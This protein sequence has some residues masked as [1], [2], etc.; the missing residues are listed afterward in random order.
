MAMIGG[1]TA[2]GRNPVRA[3]DE[4]AFC[5]STLG[6]EL[7]PVTRL[8]ARRPTLS[9]VDG[10]RVWQHGEK[11]A[12]MRDLFEQGHSSPGHQVRHPMTRADERIKL[13]NQR[14]A[15]PPSQ[16]GHRAQPPA[17]MVH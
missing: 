1:E 3:L 7:G 5:R 16:F 10:G 2:L 13:L 12:P 9:P 11:S 15:C 14:H 6:L 17:H 4:M 8:P